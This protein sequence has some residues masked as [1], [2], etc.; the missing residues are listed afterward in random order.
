MNPLSATQGFSA[1]GSQPRLEVLLS[2]VRAGNAGLSV[3]EIQKRTGIAASTLAHHLKLL[4]SAG[5]ICQE[6]NGR[7]IINRANFAHLQSLAE[8]ILQECCSEEEDHHE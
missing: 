2:L 3:G 7:T 5:L 8:F 6:K 4:N 1:I